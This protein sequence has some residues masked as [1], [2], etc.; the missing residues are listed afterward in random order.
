MLQVSVELH[1]LELHRSFSQPQ[2]QVIYTVNQTKR[3]SKLLLLLPEEPKA[4][5]VFIIVAKFFS[6]LLCLYVN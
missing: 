2:S 3:G 6:F 4:S 5:T 1:L